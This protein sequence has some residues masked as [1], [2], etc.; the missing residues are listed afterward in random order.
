[1]N[2]FSVACPA[3]SACIAVAGLKNDGLGSQ[4]TL[5]E[6]WRGS[7]ASPAQT[8]PAAFSHRA[9]HGSAGCIRAAIGEGFAMG[10]AETRTGPTI[11]A[12]M[13]QRRKSA[14]EFEQ[15]TSLCSTA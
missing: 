7:G 13:P 6:Q 4:A 11:N 12:P 3:P 2:N 15:I 14:S 10:A 8:A 9:Y 5:T 1:M